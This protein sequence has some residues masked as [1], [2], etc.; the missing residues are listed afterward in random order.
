MILPVVPYGDPVLRRETEEIE[1]SYPDLKK[2]ISDMWETMYASNGV[3]LAAPQIGKSIRIFV[4]DASS[5]ADDKDEDGNP[6]E[7]EEKAKSCVGFKKVFINPIIEEET[8]DSWVFRE[9]CLSI[10][11]IREDVKRKEKILVTYFDE[12]FDFHEEEFE[13]YAARVI[14]HEY[15]HIEGVL[16]TDLINPLR[17]RLLKKKLNDISKG[18]VDAPYRMRFPIKK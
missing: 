12:N 13:G 11:N 10:P 15:D 4:I 5:F 8:G 2:L 14:Q 17:R 1:E 16:F 9:G 6:I 7:I 3:G 18:K